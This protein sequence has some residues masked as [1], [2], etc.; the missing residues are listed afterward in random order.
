MKYL[1]CNLKSHK[2]YPE[3][4][5]Y[6]EELR[7]IKKNNIELIL[8][9]SD[10]YLSLFKREEISLCSQN[11]SLYNNSFIT[12]DSNIKGLLSLDIKYTIIGHYER[13]KYYNETEAD[14]IVKMNEALNNNLKIIYCIGETKEE[15]E[16]RVEYQVLEKQI[17]RILNNFKTT[18]FKNIIIA[19]EP[20]Y[21]LENTIEPNYK[22]IS[23]TIS[24]LKNLIYNYYEQEIDIVYGGNVTA[25]NITEFTKIKNLDGIMIGEA[26][27]DITNIEK[28]SATLKD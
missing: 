5:I 27:L 4:L 2:T 18:S 24:F 1:I 13:R 8:A 6:R 28:I 3:M 14:I 25:K 12:G 20:V 15:L 11:I 17:A 21:M 16:R 9:P 22:K 19:Y 7:S 23:E 26:S 10:I